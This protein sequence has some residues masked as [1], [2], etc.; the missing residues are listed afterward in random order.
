MSIQDD[1]EDFK[2]EIKDESLNKHFQTLWETFC[3]YEC[4]IYQYNNSVSEAKESKSIFQNKTFDFNKTMKSYI[5]LLSYA[6]EKYISFINK[7]WIFIFE[8]K[9]NIKD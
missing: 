7:V 1:Y 3:F 2:S 4:V 9:K 8:N 5:Y 6:P